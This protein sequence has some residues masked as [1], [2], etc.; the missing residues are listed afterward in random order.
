MS[1]TYRSGF[2]ANWFGETAKNFESVFI[3]D[4]ASGDETGYEFGRACPNAKVLEGKFNIGFG[5][6]NNI[7]FRSVVAAEKDYVLFVNPDCKIEYRDILFLR[8]ALVDNPEL[9]IVFPLIAD[10]EGLHSS[11]LLC[12]F[13]K[14]Y[15]EKRTVHLERNRE[16]QGVVSPACL[17]GA[18][19]MVR[20]ED[21]LKI[22]GF[23]EELFMYCEEDDLGLRMQTIGKKIGIHLGASAV[24]LGGASTK[25]SWNLSVRKAYHVRWS[26]FYM[27]DRYISAGMRRVEVFKALFSAPIAIFLYA[28]LF[29]GNLLSRWIGWSFAAVDGIFMTKIFRRIMT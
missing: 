8:Q 1:V 9:G 23:N 26:R 16:N 15:S 6:A 3:V 10:S 25:P 27:T 22:N 5:S 13:S 17:D 29:R 21:F 2:L 7:G 14:P 11:V 12:D 28:I 19:F 20:T 18:C 4:N 24:H